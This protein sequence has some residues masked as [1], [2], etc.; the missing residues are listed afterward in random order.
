MGKSKPEIGIVTTWQL[1]DNYG[2]VLQCYALQ[3]VLRQL[4]ANPFLIKYNRSKAKKI[5]HWLFVL[6]T[7]QLR[8]III[9]IIA[10]I[11]NRKVI[12]DRGFDK[13]SEIHIKSTEIIYSIAALKNNSPAADYYI[14]GSDNIW[15]DYDKGCFLE[16]GDIHIPRI[17]YA[18]S[19]GRDNISKDY[20]DKLSRALKRFTVVTV[21]EE[22]GAEICRQAGRKDAFAVPD[23]TLL[24][25]QQDYCQLYSD[26][27]ENKDNISEKYLLF[28]LLSEET[29]IDFDA[30]ISFSKQRRLKII[31]VQSNG[32]YRKM[33]E[34]FVTI[35]PTL[36]EWLSL[37]ANAEYILTNSFHGTVFSVIFNKRFGFY[38]Q[39]PR[40]DNANPSI[41]M[42]EFLHKLKLTERIITTDLQILDNPIDY[43]HI[44][45]MLNTQRESIKNCF[46]EWFKL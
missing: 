33:N 6:V 20:K 39:T 21:R 4:G 42:D 16:W 28:Y 8:R 24:L 25:T 34:E 17:A 27:N 1:P 23:P 18:P 5:S 32:N 3:E 40:I 2:S 11:T 46:K 30:I 10:R 41:R 14:C 15:L 44:N 45:A 9:S 37:I 12:S 43:Q 19:F 36:P 22:S 13:F 26:T 7:F 38:P 29:Q 35:Y 31:C